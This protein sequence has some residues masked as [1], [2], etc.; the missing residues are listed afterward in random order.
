MKSTYQQIPLK[1]VRIDDPFWSKY[2]Q[3][4]RDVVIPYQWDALN[5]RIED[6]EPSYAIRNFRIAA[7]K[8][9]GKFGGFVFQ[10]S[11]LA[12]W[13]EAV[14]YSLTTH[15]DSSLEKL[16]DEAIDLIGEAQQEDGY[17]NTYF[18]IE[19][20]ELR[21]T[22]LT[23]CHEL[24]VAGHMIEAAVAYFDATGKRKFLDIV[25]RFVDYIESVFGS[26]AGKIQGY[27][28]HQEIELA[29]VKLYKATGQEKYLR[30]SQ[31]F[32]NQRGQEPSFFVK[33]WEARGQKS[34]WGGVL[35]GPASRPNLKYHQSHAPVR[36]QKEAH[37]HAVRAV[38]MYTAMADV[39]DLTRDEGL[40]QACRTL[41]DNIIHKQ[42][43]ITGG[44]GSTHHGEAFTFDYDLPNDT[45]YAETCAS[46]G[47]IFFAQRMLQI[48][49]NSQYADV[50]ERALYNNVIGSMS[51][52]GKHYF[53][54][55][56]LEVWPKASEG[57][58]GKH[59]VKSVRQKWFGCSCC[60]PN[61]ARLVASL[62]EYIYTVSETELYVNQYIGGVAKA[63]IGGQH[64]EISQETNYPWD[65]TIKIQV[66]PEHE[67]HFTLGLRIPDWCR[68]AT[69]HIN[70]EETPIS[71]LI[72]NGYA[73]IERTWQAGDVIQLELSM[74]IQLIQSHPQ[75]RVNAGKVA[76]QRGPLV[77]CI[78]EFDNNA[79]LTSISLLTDR[80]RPLSARFDPDLLGGTMIIEGDAQ[81]DQQEDW[82]HELYRPL[83]AVT[84]PVKLRAIP[85]NSWG[86]REAGEMSVW[87]RMKP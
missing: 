11:D 69:L 62:G 7:G 39:A 44:I 4:I 31:Y 86:N 16:A 42:M 10:D 57:N 61:V 37:G 87:I 85:Y 50:I 36:A 65:G 67:Q 73:R 22:N 15:R 84:Q 71:G 9:D 82:K 23:E 81:I 40:L 5:D 53:Y 1:N 2:D 55:N 28:G 17:I 51:Q 3:L 75:L 43:Y 56:P 27:D 26:E 72:L 24:Y 80:H 48:E 33:E 41:W 70:G 32:L 47:L 30:L 79:P 6:A 68:H 38:Y 58:P 46:I 63:T 52:D 18:T 66:T 25:S 49:P 64:L 74:E 59:H 12:K 19:A 14:G 13:L 29:L 77:Y 34:F 83:K 21:W 54:V 76:I 60:P 45:I 35:P 8:E 78:E 20:P